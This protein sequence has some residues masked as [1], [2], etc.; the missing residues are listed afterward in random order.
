M[1]VRITDYGGAS[2]KPEGQIV[3]IIGHINDP[4]VDIMSVIKAYQL[5]VEFPKDV[6]RNWNLSQMKSMIMRLKKE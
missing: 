2:K 5:P 1:V 3:E 4:G 6:V